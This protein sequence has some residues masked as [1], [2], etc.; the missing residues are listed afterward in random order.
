V[1]YE[2]T[3]PRELFSLHLAWVWICMTDLDTYDWL[4]YALPVWI[5]VNSFDCHDWLGEVY[6]T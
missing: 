1:V 3:G 6:L 4:E 2:Y 5:G